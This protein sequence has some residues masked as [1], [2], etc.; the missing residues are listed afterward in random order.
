MDKGSGGQ[1]RKTSCC[2]HSLLTKAALYLLHHCVQLRGHHPDLINESVHWEGEKHTHAPSTYKRTFVSGSLRGWHT[3]RARPSS[4][5][6]QKQARKAAFWYPTKGGGCGREEN[7]HSPKL[8]TWFIP[9]LTQCG[10]EDF[11]KWADYV[12]E[13]IS[14]KQLTGN[15]HEK[16]GLKIHRLLDA[17]GK[18]PRSSRSVWGSHH[19]CPQT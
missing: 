15:L 3:P 7:T 12:Q 6:P 16:R 4:L 17:S 2:L 13:K 19:A 1:R 9:K 5:H 10:E 11:R 8:L 14:C 18:A